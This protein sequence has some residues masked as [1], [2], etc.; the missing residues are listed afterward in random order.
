MDWLNHLLD[1]FSSSDEKLKAIADKLDKIISMLSGIPQGEGGGEGEFNITIPQRFTTPENF[2]FIEN[3]VL[4]PTDGEESIVSYD[5]PKGYVLYLQQ[6]M[7]SSETTDML[8]T[9]LLDT[10][11][12]PLENDVFGTYEQPFDLTA[13]GYRRGVRVKT[14]IQLKAKNNTGAPITVS[15]RVIGELEYVGE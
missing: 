2:F 15:A 3:E 13:N 4:I 9:L 5:V 14:K 8:Y 12:I 1:Y 6:I 10:K 7:Q 11:E